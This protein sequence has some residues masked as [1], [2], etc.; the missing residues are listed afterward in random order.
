MASFH[1]TV[2]A[3]RLPAAPPP[4]V[5]TRDLDLLPSDGVD[6]FCH[7]ND[8]LFAVV[9]PDTVAQDFRAAISR[10]ADLQVLFG[11]AFQSRGLPLSY[12]AEQRIYDARR[13]LRIYG[14]PSG[15]YLKSWAPAN[16]A[17][18]IGLPLVAGGAVAAPTAATTT[19]Q[20]VQQY[21]CWIGVLS[22]FEAEF[23]SREDKQ[24]ILEGAS[25]TESPRSSPPARG[26]SD[27][28]AW[29]ISPMPSDIMPNGRRGEQS[30]IPRFSDRRVAAEYK[31]PR[32]SL[33]LVEHPSH[34]IEGRLASLPLDGHFFEQ[35]VNLFC[36]PNG[37][38][39]VKANIMAHSDINKEFASPCDQTLS[40]A[41]QQ[42]HKLRKQIKHRDLKHMFRMH[43]LLAKEAGELAQQAN[44]VF[45]ER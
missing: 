21:R 13:E 32:S 35:H 44:E 33:P 28:P 40:T 1:P 6:A 16:V 9:D 7:H 23:L 10:Q 24:A 3:L 39:S 30:T 12:Q 19:D 36:V 29:F 38:S 27:R 37:A 2:G 45:K 18:I 25:T 15:Q 11:I 5:Q 43:S 17:I 41:C 31:K 42:R 26:P 4:A 14:H 34:R 22:A 8:P 20:T